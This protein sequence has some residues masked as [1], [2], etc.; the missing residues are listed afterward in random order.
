M[1]EDCR[2]EAAGVPGRRGLGARGGGAAEADTLAGGD[3]TVGGLAAPEGRAH[4]ARGQGAAG[5][6]ARGGGRQPR[7]GRAARTT[8]ARSPPGAPRAPDPT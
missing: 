8:T 4:G 6:R 1:D 2:D 7:G 3:P 5:S